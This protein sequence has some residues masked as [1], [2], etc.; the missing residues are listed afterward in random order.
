ME[1]SSDCGPDG[2]KT[3]HGLFV[4]NSVWLLAPEVKKTFLL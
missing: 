3:M 4:C 1:F 2:G